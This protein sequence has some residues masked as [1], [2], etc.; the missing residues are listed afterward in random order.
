MTFN[1]IQFLIFF[2]IVA[3]L[4]FVIPTKYRWIMLLAASYY[5]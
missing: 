1:S 3:I 5:F 4:H 2:P